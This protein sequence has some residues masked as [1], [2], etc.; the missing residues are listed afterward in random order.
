MAAQLPGTVVF[1]GHRRSG[2]KLLMR[3]VLEYML[4]RPQAADEAETLELEF[5]L[6]SPD[7]IWAPFSGDP[8]VKNTAIRGVDGKLEM[9]HSLMGRLKASTMTKPNAHLIVVF[10]AP[11]INNDSWV[12]PFLMAN[13]SDYNVS[14]LMYKTTP[15]TDFYPAWRFEDLAH[16]AVFTWD[17]SPSVRES[18]YKCFT[19]SFGKQEDWERHYQKMTNEP[20][21]GAG[22]VVIEYRGSGNIAYAVPVPAVVKI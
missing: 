13:A 1:C 10:E 16:A 7:P 9:S 11:P 12:W 14:V 22:A 19:S 8:R 21:P 17:A 4:D 2:V 3:R 5:Y 15:P 6:A 20:T 18:V